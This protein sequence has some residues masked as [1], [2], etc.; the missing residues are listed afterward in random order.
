M[1][2]APRQPLPVPTAVAAPRPAN[3]RASSQIE[4]EIDDEIEFHLEMRTLEYVRQGMPE[5]AARAAALAAF[6]DLRKIRNACRRAKLGDSLMLARVQTVL[7]IVLLAAVVVLAYGMYT[8]QSANEQA[9]GAIAKSLEQLVAAKSMEQPAAV[10][11]AGSA[12]SMTAEAR[13]MRRRYA[14]GQ[15]EDDMKHHPERVAASMA[16][17]DNVTP[18]T[19]KVTLPAAGAT[20]VDPATSEIRVKFDKPMQ[21]KSWSWVQVSKETFPEID[22]TREVHYLK[23]KKT[24]VLPVKLVAGKKY[25]VWINSNRFQ[26]FKTADGTPAVPYELT[27]ETRK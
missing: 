4:A 14:A 21:D 7:I 17:L 24:C 27:F 22:K 10:A 20:G 5:D 19:V 25:T 1:R 12:D 8:V 9:L 3:V 15:V 23:D 6:G 18:P 11:S 13:E 26:N 2:M 16:F